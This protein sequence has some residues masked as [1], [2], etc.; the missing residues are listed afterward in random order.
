MICVKQGYESDV[1]ALGLGPDVLSRDARSSARSVREVR[2]TALLALGVLVFSET[3]TDRADHFASR[4]PSLA[5][6]TMYLARIVR[7]TAE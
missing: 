5:I 3:G 4:S 2:F 7:P 1:F 6:V